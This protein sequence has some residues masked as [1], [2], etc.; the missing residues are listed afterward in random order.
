MIHPDNHSICV[1][2]E[3]GHCTRFG[4]RMTGRPFDICHGDALTPDQQRAYRLN[5]ATLAASQGHRSSFDCE[6]RGE[7][8]EHAE[9][10]TCSNS[11]ATIPVFG[12]ALH[13]KTIL[14]ARNDDDTL[15]FSAAI[16]AGQQPERWQCNLC[17]D[18]FHVTE[19]TPTGQIVPLFHR[20]WTMLG[21]CSHWSNVAEAFRLAFAQAAE[22]VP[23]GPSFGHPRGI[24]ICGGGRKYFPSAYVAMRIIRHLGCDWPIELWH[25]G[26]QEQ[27]AAMVELTEPLAVTWRD[28][29]AV[30][31]EHGL[32]CNG[33][34]PLKAIAL[35]YS[36]FAETMLIDADCYPAIHPGELLDQ[37]PY[38][39][40]GAIFFP[41]SSD[42]KPETYD[43]FGAPRRP[44]NLALESGQLVVDKRRHWPATWLAAWLNH[45]SDWV[46]RHVYGDKDTFLMAWLKAG[47]EF[48]LPSR[49]PQCSLHGAFQHVDFQGRVAFVHRIHAKFTFQAWGS[50]WFPSGQHPTDESAFPHAA[51]TAAAVEV[52]N[53]HLSPTL[54]NEPL[55]ERT[56]PAG[57]RT[58]VDVGANRGVWSNVLSRKFA[59][60]VAVEPQPAMH[61]YLQFR[62]K[63]ELQPV[64]LA[65]QIGAGRLAEAANDSTRQSTKVETNGGDI[66]VV[67]LDSLDLKDVDFVKID[68]EGAEGSVLRGGM[69][70]INRWRPKLVIEW[71]STAMLQD[72]R[73]LL[74]TLDYSFEVIRDPGGEFGWLV[75][76][77]PLPT[78]PAAAL[79][80]RG[81]FEA[82]ARENHRQVS[83]GVVELFGTTLRIVE[84]DGWL[85]HHLLEDGY[86]ESW[87]SLAIARRLSRGMRCLDVGANVGYYT[88][89]MRR[90]VGL[91]GHVTA[92]EPSRRLCELMS[93]SVGANGWKNVAI[94]AAAAGDRDGTA[95]LWA[96]DDRR[97]SGSVLKGF[98]NGH[99]PVECETRTLSTI[100]GGQRIDFAKID[101]DGGEEALWRGGRDVLR[102]IGA[103]VLEVRSDR[104]ADPA[105]F[106]AEICG[107]F[108][109][110]RVIDL[111]GSIRRIDCAEVLAHASSDY[112]LWLER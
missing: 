17:R 31:R 4:R 34:W 25:L 7:V 66:P 13:G 79:D 101:V 73:G 50:H 49:R 46:Y 21:S 102:E 74:G 56:I 86:W 96:T 18:E 57:G 70:T 60:V 51:W 97:L 83:P 94:V 111:E 41:D 77:P 78:I 11:I 58:A 16:R 2:D 24:A 52:G 19:Q 3:P 99:F 68:A 61:P 109:E 71:H 104:Y 59:R 93:Q 9:C 32:R 72:C 80:S 39:E 37:R 100:C 12:C 36:D 107:V 28:G 44:D 5:W 20:G 15:A 55:L 69:G 87:I 10:R 54:V 48:S 22:R 45:N 40:T 88:A 82:W 106:L 76:S 65:D 47:H 81:R 91:T 85:G 90:Q 35:A 6:H 30:A 103:I 23:P 42:L 63:I 29:P 33:G 38:R 67:T 95:T 14:G 64:A 43:W 75:A 27:E 53:Q 112:L 92:I 8:I 110:L 62:P 108:P 26:Q 1:C 105:A 89:L 98:R 84:D